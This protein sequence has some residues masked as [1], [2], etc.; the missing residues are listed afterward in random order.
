MTQHRS[1]PRG[2]RMPTFPIHAAARVRPSLAAVTLTTFLALSPSVPQ[3]QSVE[4]FSPQGEVKAV[5]HVPARYARPIIPWGDPREIEPFA[6]DWV[7]TG[8]GRWADM[9]NWVY[10]FDRDLPAG[11]RCSFTLK[12]L[13]FGLE[14]P[15]AIRVWSA[16]K[17][18]TSK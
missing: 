15:L 6:I 4:F 18:G 17:P 7:E 9:K 13:S 5:R 2:P 14:N 12:A 11:V 10:D 1:T 3:A 16:A 8:K